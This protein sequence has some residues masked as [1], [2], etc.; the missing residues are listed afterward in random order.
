MD[1]IRKMLSELPKKDIINLFVDTI[2]EFEGQIKF[3]TD[4]IRKNNQQIKNATKILNKLKS[5]VSGE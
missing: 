4:S 3:V 2:T 1:E 5:E